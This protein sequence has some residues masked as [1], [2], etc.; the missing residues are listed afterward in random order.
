[1]AAAGPC[2][3]DINVE[4]YHIN[5]LP[6]FLIKH[7]LFHS[8]SAMTDVVFD[9]DNSKMSSQVQEYK[10]RIIPNPPRHVPRR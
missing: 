4:S 5:I 3:S 7:A 1:M 8:F 10:N 9:S 6:D 2:Q